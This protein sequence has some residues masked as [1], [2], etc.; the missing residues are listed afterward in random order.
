MEPGQGVLYITPWT[1]CNF[2]PHGILIVTLYT[3]KQINLFSVFGNHFL[4]LTVSLVFVSLLWY[5]LPIIRKILLRQNWCESYV[6][7]LKLKL[8]L[9]IKFIYFVLLFWP[10]LSFISNNFIIF[11]IEFLIFTWN[12]FLSIYRFIISISRISIILYLVVF[13][14]LLKPMGVLK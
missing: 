10:L 1:Y 2:N 12:I 9:K 11:L 8:K 6:T 14:S 5:L 3:L 7:G 4:S 13:G